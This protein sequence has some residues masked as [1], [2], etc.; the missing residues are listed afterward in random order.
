M[1]SLKDKK[2]VPQKSNQPEVKKP[3]ANQQKEEVNK[4]SSQTVAVKKA[5]EKMEKDLSAKK[6][7]KGNLTKYSTLSVP[8]KPVIIPE[9]SY[10]FNNTYFSNYLREQKSSDNRLR[11]INK[12]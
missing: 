1:N 6:E 10:N 11:I 9:Q 3:T 5:S 4:Y 8:D 12:N 2:D 7:D